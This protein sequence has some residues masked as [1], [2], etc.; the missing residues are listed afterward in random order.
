M[1]FNISQTV[2]TIQWR[3][4][5]L[6]DDW[7]NLHSFDHGDEEFTISAIDLI[8]N[9]EHLPGITLEGNHTISIRGIG[10]GEGDSYST[11]IITADIML[12]NPSKEFS[13]SNGDG[14]G[15]SS[16]ALAIGAFA[17]VFLVVIL[18]AGLVTDKE[19]GSLASVDVSAKQYVESIDDDIESIV[20]AELD[21]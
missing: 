5:H 11:A 18:I 1:K 7:T 17:I 3:S 19:E 9:L 15:V 14:D 12:M 6:R 16:I 20:D 21:A 4:N 2:D 8:H 13:S 10:N